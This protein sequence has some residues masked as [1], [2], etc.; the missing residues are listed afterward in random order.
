MLKENVITSAY[1]DKLITSPLIVTFLVKI[2]SF[3]FFVE[4]DQVEEKATKV[5]SSH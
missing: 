5:N 3:F 4:K 1:N 2:M